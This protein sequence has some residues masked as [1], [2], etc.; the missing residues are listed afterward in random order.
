[1]LGSFLEATTKNAILTHTDL[2]FFTQKVGFEHSE[3]EH[4]VIKI[5]V[6][7]PYFKYLLLKDW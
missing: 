1:M 5:L 6:H 2:Y 3:G 7:I 4:N